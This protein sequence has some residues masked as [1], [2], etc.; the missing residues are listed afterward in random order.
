MFPSPK[1][2]DLRNNVLHCTVLYC[3]VLY[4]IVLY[5]TVLYC[6]VLYCTV[7]YCTLLYCTVLYSSETLQDNI[8]G[9]YQTRFVLTQDRHVKCHRNHQAAKVLILSSFYPQSP[10]VEPWVFRWTFSPPSPPPTFECKDNLCGQCGMVVVGG[11]GLL[12]VL[13]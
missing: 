5:C 2:S 9:G 7:L 1:L 8:S 4:F 11:G 10:E 6:T 3:T 12:W 13:H